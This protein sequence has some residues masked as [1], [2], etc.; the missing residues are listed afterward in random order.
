MFSYIEIMK[1]RRSLFKSL[2]YLTLMK[3]YIVPTVNEF[4]VGTMRL[5]CERLHFSNLYYIKD[6]DVNERVENL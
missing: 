4:T 3:Y 5:R 1:S 6:A 2:Y